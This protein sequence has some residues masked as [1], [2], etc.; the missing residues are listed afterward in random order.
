M[1]ELLYMY[2][3]NTISGNPKDLWKNPIC[4]TIAIQLGNNRETHRL[5]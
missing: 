1:Y 3:Y 4:V 5:I 2:M